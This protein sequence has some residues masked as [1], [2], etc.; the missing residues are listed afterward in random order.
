MNQQKNS[1]G[2]IYNDKKFKKYKEKMKDTWMKDTLNH[3]SLV[4]DIEFFFYNLH[5]KYSK[6]VFMIALY[7]FQCFCQMPSPKFIVPYNVYYIK[8]NSPENLK[9]IDTFRRD[10]NFNK[11]INFLQTIKYPIFKN[12]FWNVT[13]PNALGSFISKEHCL[14]AL[15]L[16]KSLQDHE[17]FLSSGVISFIGNNY[18]FQNTFLNTFYTLINRL[19]KDPESYVWCQYKSDLFESIIQESLERALN[20]LNPQQIEAINLFHQKYSEKA[21]EK[22]FTDIILFNIQNIWPYSPLFISNEMLYKN[23]THESQLVTDLEDKYVKSD[24]AKENRKKFLEKFFETAKNL[25][26]DGEI[27]IAHFFSNITDPVIISELDRAILDSIYNTSTDDAREFNDL[28]S[29]KLFEY[30]QE[31]VFKFKTIFVQLKKQTSL[32]YKPKIIHSQELLNRW[33]KHVSDCKDLN[34]NPL[35]PI[36][37]GHQID[38]E[39]AYYGLYK[40]Y[41]EQK[42]NNKFI[43]E[44][45]KLMTCVVPLNLHDESQKVF[46]QI[47]SMILADKAL[48]NYH[49]DKLEDFLHSLYAAHFASLFCNIPKD[50]IYS[51]KNRT[52]FE[53]FSELFEKVFDR[54]EIEINL[55]SCFNEFFNDDKTYSS[56]K[57]F[58][59]QYLNLFK[60]EINCAILKDK[61]FDS[62]K[63]KGIENACRDL[64]V[65]KR[66]TDYIMSSLATFGQIEYSFVV[67]HFLNKPQKIESEKISFGEKTF[68]NKKLDKFLTEKMDDLGVFSYIESVCYCLFEQF[69]SDDRSVLM[70]NLL[71]SVPV[72]LKMMDQFYFV[73]EGDVEPHPLLYDL[74]KTKNQFD[75]VK[76]V[77]EL[78]KHI[79]RFANTNYRMCKY[80]DLIDENI[81][82]SDNVDAF[83][84]NLI[85]LMIEELS[86]NE[87]IKYF[88]SINYIIEKLKN[89]HDLLD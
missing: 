43:E 56:L 32:K 53:P 83:F 27:L 1:V 86:E 5:E 45:S 72:I 14:I 23:I 25:T 88:S 54:N 84:V 34:L 38:P 24:E 71:A 76:M 66:M 37:N 64:V 11:L 51:F 74:I 35:S 68:P 46:L 28:K 40:E 81:N 58:L 87:E 49:E 44:V 59:A 13:F 55:K 75:N 67:I 62:T 4:T 19:C 30:I 7:R 63:K 33:N 57:N 61:L 2:T 21:E 31:K 6:N 79:L 50:T 16:L 3:Q 60:T 65:D 10:E 36:F 52:K 69:K 39:V 26:I 41:H 9:S 47:Y 20:K 70:G 29:D 17:D 85:S 8:G 48:N 77:K 80:E 12:Y 89:L 82:G 15:K 78:A 22:I 42:A 73:Q 18:L